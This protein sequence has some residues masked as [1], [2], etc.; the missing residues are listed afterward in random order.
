MDFNIISQLQ[1][2]MKPQIKMIMN[3]TFS[4]SVSHIKSD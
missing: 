4:F 1:V 3:K 2:Q